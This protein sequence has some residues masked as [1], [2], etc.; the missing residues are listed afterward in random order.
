LDE[1]TKALLTAAG[2]LLSCGVLPHGAAAAPPNPIVTENAHP[3]TTA[4]QGRLV[5][6]V[7]LYGTEITAAPGDRI[8]L[9][10]STDHRYRIV[11]YRLGWYGGAGARQVACL[12]SCATDEQG[13]VQG[14]A[15]PP[16]TQPARANWPVT[17]VVQTGSDWTSGYYIVEAVL[18]GRS[19][20]PLVGTTYFIL[21][22]PPS[23]QPSQ[24]LVQV[25][26]NTW[27]AYNAWGGRSLYN[28]T[29]E[30]AY[31]VSFQR[32]FDHQATTPLWW[33]IQLVRF[34]EREGYDVSYATDIDTDRAPSSLLQHRLVIVAGH[35]EYW[36]LAIRNAFES[37]L[38][39]GTNLAFMGSN[40]AY[41]NIKYEDGGQT[42][43]TYKSMYDPNP[44]VTTKTAMFREI[45][46]PECLLL[47]VQH[48]DI[49]VLAHPLDYTVTSAGA[50]DPW[51]AGTGFLAGD[52]IAGVVGREHDTLT[53][54]PGCAK[55]G[56]TVLFHYDGGGVDVNGD[57]V[58]YTAPSG[59]RVFASGAQQFSWALD[60]WRSDD[61]IAPATPVGSDRSAPVD[62]R[63]QHFMR[64]ALDDLTRP[65][66]PTA[67]RKSRVPGGVRIRVDKPID[68]RVVGRLVYRIHDGDSPVLVCQGRGRCVV[69]RATA[70]G[71]Y[72]FAVEYV[73]LWGRRSAPTYSASWT[74]PQE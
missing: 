57:A 33:E 9:H 3:G 34:L 12:P 71:T 7:E 53:G 44:D 1:M 10:V 41:W 26:V 49:R 14:G 8:H 6:G 30:R 51:L 20:V 60:S 23:A 18:A 17:D 40:D 13:H 73:D 52:R 56:E 66:A 29:M 69:P 24:I 22:Q 36:T 38:A 48:A 39:A 16:A 68:P 21:R 11:V 32:P 59:A 63:V 50:S 70:P 31:R 46:R 4:W 45:G 15:D 28:F 65:A 42:I 37:A 72:R 43:F 54:F 55:P 67:V 64:N 58:R 2:V 19:A 35:D 5:G 61:T 74:L 25:P 62:A 47:G 27:E